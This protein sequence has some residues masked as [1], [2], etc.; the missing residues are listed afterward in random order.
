MTPIQAQTKKCEALLRKKE[1]LPKG[2]KVLRV[3]P[4][5]LKMRAKITPQT[6]LPN[7]K[8]IKEIVIGRDRDQGAGK[9]SKAGLVFVSD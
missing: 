3:S 2:G 1:S 7:H 9:I 6:M 8:R 5:M 4:E